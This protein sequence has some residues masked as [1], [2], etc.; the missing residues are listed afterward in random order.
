MSGYTVVA[1]A[2]YQLLEDGTEVKH[3]AGSV[4]DTFSKADAARHLASGNIV[5]HVEAAEFVAPVDDSGVDPN[6]QTGDGGGE[7]TAKPPNVANKP[8]L[9]N[10][11]IE[12]GRKH[13]GTREELDELTKDQLWEYINAE[14]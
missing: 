6:A 5:A 4:V 8:V 10:W 1:T 9:V 13:G 11:L 3:R 7:S 12:H 2:V 14:D